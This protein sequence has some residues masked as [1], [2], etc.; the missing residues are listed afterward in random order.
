MNFHIR[1]D[2]G[3]HTYGDRLSFTLS[4]LGRT[5][6]RNPVGYIPETEWSSGILVNGQVST[7]TNSILTM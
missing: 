1:Q 3:G 5:F 7:H 2:M 6:V 4:G